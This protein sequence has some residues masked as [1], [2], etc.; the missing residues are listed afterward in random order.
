MQKQR[1][2]NVNSLPTQPS[3]KVAEAGLWTIDSTFCG[4]N[5]IDEWNKITRTVH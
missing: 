3:I 4:Y 2:H 1:L 5:D